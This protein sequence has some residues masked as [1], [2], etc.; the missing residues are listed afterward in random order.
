MRLDS[1][2]VPSRGHSLDRV[3]VVGGFLQARARN[4]WYA[5]AVMAAYDWAA[6]NPMDSI[7]ISSLL[8]GSRAVDN[9][10]D[11]GLTER[12]GSDRRAKDL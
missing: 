12:A 7:G 1:P 10:R 11:L 5:T 2:M 4:R 3:R 6:R 9:T 8:R